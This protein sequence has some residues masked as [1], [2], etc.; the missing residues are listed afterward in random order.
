VGPSIGLAFWL[1]VSQS[2]SALISHEHAQVAATQPLRKIKYILICVTKK[3]QKEE[4]NKTYF[5]MFTENVL[6]F[7]MFVSHS[8]GV[9][10]FLDYSMN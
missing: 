2:T 4:D 6:I 9:N 10:I 1:P 7:M 5:L 8:S 3:L